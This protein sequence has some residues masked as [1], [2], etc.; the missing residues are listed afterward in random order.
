MK[1]FISLAALMA[2][3]FALTGC[4]KNEITVGNGENLCA[5]TVNVGGDIPANTKIAGAVADDNVIRDVQI[6]VFRKAARDQDSKIDAAVR[7]SGLNAS[8]NY[9]VPE[10]LNCT[11]GSREVW[12][13]VNAPAD[14]TKGTDA[15][16]SL[17]DL[18]VRTTVLGDN[19]YGTG[20]KSFVMAGNKVI[21]LNAASQTVSVDVQR[22]ACKVVI[23]GIENK[24]ILPVYQ[25]EG[26]LKI[27]GAYLMSV[28]GC[29][30]F[31]NLNSISTA[32]TFLPASGIADSYWH[33][34]NVK[35]SN[36]LIT[37]DYNPVKSLGYNGKLTDLSTFYAYPNDADPSSAAAWSIRGTLLVVSAT[38]KGDVCYY[39]I[40]LPKLESNKCY[41]VNLVIKRRGSEE[42]WRPVEYDDMTT[43][44][45][46]TSWT[47]VPVSSEI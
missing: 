9:T 27:T 18:K 26:S 30:K 12:V 41:E 7:I 25:A 6:L 33:G 17:Q 32:R 4:Q 47:P 14:Y 43:N 38:L 28:A 2:A 13:V 44:I 46:V 20:G 15:V 23:K 1:K 36:T 24:F 16:L 42:P 40:Q 31:D 21:D 22:M 10:S 8:G 5:L 37:E 11:R 34:R 39:P 35:D 3:V 45:T 19:K 29:Q